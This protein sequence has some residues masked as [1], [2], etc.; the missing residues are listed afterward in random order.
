MKEYLREQREYNNKDLQKRVYEI[1]TLRKKMLLDSM[2][3]EDIEKELKYH[4]GDTVCYYTDVYTTRKT[5]YFIGML[6][7]FILPYDINAPDIFCI[8]PSEHPE[9]IDY[10]SE[11]KIIKAVAVV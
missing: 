2:T 3:K 4:E 10:I 7:S 5:R 8:R 1:L 6:D 9:R 11:H